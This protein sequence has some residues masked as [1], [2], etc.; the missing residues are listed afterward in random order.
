MTQSN[1]SQ[2]S[3]LKHKRLEKRES[4]KAKAWAN[5]QSTSAPSSDQMNTI[6]KYPD[7][8]RQKEGNFS[9]EKFGESILSK[10]GQRLRVR[11]PSKFN[12]PSKHNS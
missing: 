3:P 7:F 5:K 12:S 4:K 8:K 11:P 1:L 9:G 2:K 6:N 10:P